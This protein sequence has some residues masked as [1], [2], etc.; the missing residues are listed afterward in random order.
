MKLR[1]ETKITSDYLRFDYQSLVVSLIKKSLSTEDI[2]YFNELYP[3][4]GKQK[5][6]SFTFSANITNFKAEGSGVDVKIT[7]DKLIINISTIDMKFAIILYNA[8][9][10]M[11]NKE[12][13]F[14]NTSIEI[15]GITK[16]KEFEINSDVVEFR[17]LSPIYLKKKVNRKD[18]SVDMDDMDTYIKVLNYI[19]DISLKEIRGYG[20]KQELQFMPIEYKK[21]VSQQK[22]SSQSDKLKSLCKNVYKGNFVLRGNI[23][24]LKDLYG[25]GLGFSRGVGFGNIEVVRC[26]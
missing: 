24:D 9:L 14:K 17:T 10:K 4:E 6:K 8:L 13:V 1:V 12:F 15:I 22:Y 21:I 19:S 20:L 23:N 18:Y 16:V 7:G 3:K 5:T 25:I 26:L 2:K 11:R